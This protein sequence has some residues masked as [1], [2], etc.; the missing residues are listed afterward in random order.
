MVAVAVAVIAI[1]GAV[2]AVAL[3]GDST[4]SEPADTSTATTAAPA[5]DGRVVTGQ[6]YSF[7][8]PAGFVT[9]SSG[10]YHEASRP[11]ENS[12]TESQWRSTEDADTEIH[13]D[14]TKGF[15]GTIENAARGVR[16][17]RTK[18]PTFREYSF[19]AYTREDG[20]EA[21]RWHFSTADE[22]VELHRVAYYLAGC[23][24]GF[25]LLGVAPDGAWDRLSEVFAAT[26]SSLRPRC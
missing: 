6:S 9:E 25:A 14:Y 19:G 18:G 21:W 3:T 26:E 16:S 8:L 10:V 13:I 11:G 1:S 17:R 22:G 4:P 15:E 5:G 20:S 12:Y 24:T 2:A 7:R 23:D